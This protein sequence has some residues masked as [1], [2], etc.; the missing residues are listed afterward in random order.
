MQRLV[1]EDRELSRQYRLINSIKGGRSQTTLMM[2]VLT[3]GFICLDTWR[4]FASYAGIA[5]FPNFTMCSAKV[6]FFLGCF[7]PIAN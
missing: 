6:D 3:K 7:L 2:I 5:P 4:K 1:E